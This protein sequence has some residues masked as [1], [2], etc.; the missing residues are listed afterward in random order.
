MKT[1]H[2]TAAI[3]LSV[4]PEVAR[5]LD[6]AKKTYPTLSDPEILKVGLAKLVTED[7]VGDDRELRSL[8]GGSLNLDGCLDDAVEDIYRPATIGDVHRILARPSKSQPITTKEKQI[9]EGKKVV[10]K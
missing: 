4:T 8:A 10:G 2:H 3:R 9:I 1:I 7:V 6:Q 5:A